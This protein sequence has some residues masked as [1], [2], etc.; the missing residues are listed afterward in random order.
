MTRENRDDGCL[1]K[2]RQAGNFSFFGSFNSVLLSGQ[3][4]AIFSPLSTFSAKLIGPLGG[5][6]GSY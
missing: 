2:R 3:R 5:F 6:K 1:S 4:T